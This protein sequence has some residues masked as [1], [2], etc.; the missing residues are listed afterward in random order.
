M[1]LHEFLE[2]KSERKKKGHFVKEDIPL[3]VA[4]FVIHSGLEST[5][6]TSIF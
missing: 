1:V 3:A 5:S 2:K 6:S 4:A